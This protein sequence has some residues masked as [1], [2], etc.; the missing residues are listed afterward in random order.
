MNG[1]TTEFVFERTETKVGR[2]LVAFIIDVLVCFF[3]F[4]PASVLSIKL[5]DICGLPSAYLLQ[6]WFC[7]SLAWPIIYFAVLTGLI[8]RTPGRFICRLRVT[9]AHNTRLKFWRGFCREILKFLGIWFG[10]LGVFIALFQILY[11]GDDAWYDSICGT[12]V[13]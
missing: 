1:R 12:E 10:G 11:L 6:T 13:R 9:G 3:S 8:G 7:F 2:R 5:M 4:F